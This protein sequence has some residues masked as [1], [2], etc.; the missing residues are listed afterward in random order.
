M[1]KL[2]IIVMLCCTTSAIADPLSV[3]GK[4]VAG[5]Q[6]LSPCWPTTTLHK[7]INSA[8]FALQSQGIL[9]ASIDPA[10][11]AF[12]MFT[13]N[14]GRFIAIVRQQEKSISCVIAAGDSLG[15]L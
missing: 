3:L 2:L 7:L 12:L 8:G 13:K 10:R 11:P 9:T 15:T 5:M 6:T 4:P 14:D 1:A